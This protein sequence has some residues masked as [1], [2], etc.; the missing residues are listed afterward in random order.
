[1]NIFRKVYR[2]LSSSQR[3]DAFVLMPL[4]VF[5]MFLEAISLGAVVPVTSIMVKG[6]LSQYPFLHFATDG[7]KIGE[8][9]II[10]YAMLGLAGLFLIKNIFLAFLAWRQANFSYSIR[11]LLSW[12]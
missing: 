1:M 4:M 10:I 12:A 5:G 3:R 9:K 6:N 8:E 7:L 11:D 2:L